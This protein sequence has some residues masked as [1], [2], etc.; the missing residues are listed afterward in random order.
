MKLE[1]IKHSDVRGKELNYLQVTNALG[2]KYLI[3]IGNKTFEELIKMQKEEEEEEHIES[4]DT[5]NYSIKEEESEIEKE[6]NKYLDK[7]EN[8]KMIRIDELK[9]PISGSMKISEEIF[10][11]PE[12][13]TMTRQQMD[14]RVKTDMKKNQQVRNKK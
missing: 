4:E 8:D 12:K 6:A 10:N 7:F 3:N 2:T 1:T 9:E 5:V 14:E 13:I 11:N